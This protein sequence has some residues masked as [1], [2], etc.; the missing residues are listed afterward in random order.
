MLRRN[1][2]LNGPE[3]NQHASQEFTFVHVTEI[4][5]YIGSD[6]GTSYH[7]TFHAALWKR[8]LVSLETFSCFICSAL[9]WLP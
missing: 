5:G 1:T 4:S 3:G 2:L 8:R 6:I 9:Y 7:V